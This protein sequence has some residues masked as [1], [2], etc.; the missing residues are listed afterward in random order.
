[1]ESSLESTLKGIT[2]T[3]YNWKESAKIRRTGLDAPVIVRHVGH[4]NKRRQATKNINANMRAVN[5]VD[6]SRNVVR[7]YDTKVMYI[8][9]LT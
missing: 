3:K 1:M 9:N 6:V 7:W 8:V 2:F 4:S 5:K